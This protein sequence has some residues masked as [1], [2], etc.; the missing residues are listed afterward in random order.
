MWQGDH[1]EIDGFLSGLFA[2]V[3]VGAVARL[4]VRGYQPIGCLITLLIG[5]VGAGVGWWIGDAA[6]W[7]FWLTFA[8]QIV[9]GALLVLPFSVGTR[10]RF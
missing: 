8:T 2:A 10:D 1:V 3:V 4:I 5:L 6:G 9:I 7:G